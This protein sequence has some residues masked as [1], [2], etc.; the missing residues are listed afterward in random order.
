MNSSLEDIAQL[1]RK[2]CSILVTSH[3]FPDGDSVGCILALGNGLR[4]IGKKAT[5]VVD[6]FPDRYRFIPGT[7][8][9]SPWSRIT[10][11]Y[12]LGVVVDCG[13][14]VQVGNGIQIRELCSTIVNIDHHPTNK[15]FGDVNYLRPSAGACGE[16]I[17]DLL[18]ILGVQLNSDLALALYSAIVTD[19]G[20]FKYDNTTSRTHTIAARL[21]ELGV[22]PSPVAEILFDSRPLAHLRL[23]GRALESLEVTEDGLVAWMVL[24]AATFA[25]LEAEDEATDGV[26][27]YARNIDGVEAALL[28]RELPDGRVRVSVR[29]RKSLD[30]CRFAQNFGGGGHQRAAGFVADLPLP[31][32]VETTVEAIRDAVR[33]TGAV[34]GD[35]G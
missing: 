3:A 33:D 4:K 28:F 16:I 31:Q 22:H 34:V 30:A 27:N 25:K 14:L 24:P 17:Y 32:A 29:S 5:M 18:E 35:R 11:R 6:G 23:L 12:D 13:D 21:L 7:E 8:D 1:I 26:V 15:F 9:V 10:E 20:S 2:G 19:T